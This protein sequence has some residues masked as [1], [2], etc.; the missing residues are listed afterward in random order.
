MLAPEPPAQSPA[1]GPAVHPESTV[2]DVPTP[3]T[4]APDGVGP[5]EHAV[6]PLP[7]MHDIS[8][9]PRAIALDPVGT[10]LGFS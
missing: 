1:A 9:S 2:G 7:L 4:P 6:A 5:A 10:T 8:S 3:Q